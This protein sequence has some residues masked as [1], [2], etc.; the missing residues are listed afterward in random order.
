MN[1]NMATE[2]G[3][4]NAIRAIHKGIMSKKLHENYKTV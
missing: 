2:D 3:V 1:K 4:S